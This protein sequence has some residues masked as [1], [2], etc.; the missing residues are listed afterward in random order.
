M[1]EKDTLLL[2]ISL[3]ERAQQDAERLRMHVDLLHQRMDLIQSALTSVM[4]EDLEDE[5]RQILAILEE[6]KLGG[7][8]KA[9]HQKEDFEIDQRDGMIAHLRKLVEKMG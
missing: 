9:L 6:S 5:E 1:T 8:M 4:G 2:I 7:K 3:A